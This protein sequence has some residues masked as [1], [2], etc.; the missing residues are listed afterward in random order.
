MISISLRQLVDSADSLRS[1]G[2]KPLKARSAYAV[3]KL[4]KATDIELANFNE[5]HMNLVKKFGRKNEQ[6]QLDIDEQ[7]N[8]HIAP[9]ELDN[10]NKET[11]ELL[12]TVVEI[13]ANKVRIEDIE[14]L[15]FTPSEMSVL[16]EFIEFE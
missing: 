5:V 1:L 11:Q 12:D 13:N 16:G 4:L 14:D 6:G 15:E 8:A 7:G 10:Y 3:S 9:E 2:Q